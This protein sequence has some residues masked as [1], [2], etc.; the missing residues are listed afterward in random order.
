MK[1]RGSSR[2]E[3]L[4]SLLVLYPAVRTA[5]PAGRA[6]EPGLAGYWPL[7]ADTRDYSV[8]KNHG[9]ANSVTLPGASFDGTTSHLEIPDARHLHFG[10]SD[11]S[12]SLWTRVKDG[13][14]GLAGDLIAKYDPATR[15]GFSVAIKGSSGGYNSQGTDQHLHFGTDDGRLSEWEDCGRPNPTSNYISNS[16]TVFDGNLYAATTDGQSEADWAHVYRYAGGKSWVDCGRVGRQRNKGVGPMIVHGSSLYAATWSYDWERVDK[17]VLDSCNVYR[18]AGEQNWEDCGQPGQ[19]RRLFGIAA[20]KGTL[21]TVGDDKRCYVYQGGKKWTACR[22][23]INFVHPMAVYNGKLYLG[24]FGGTFDGRFHQA[25]VQSYDGTEWSSEGCPM[26]PT[27]HEDQIHALNVYRGRLYATT[28]PN[29][30]VGVLKENGEWGDCGRLG[31]STESN[32]LVVYNGK[33]YAGTIPS[34]EIYRY[35]TG[36]DWTRLKRFCP[37]DTAPTKRRRWG[38]VTSLTAYSGKLFAGL[39]SY[40]SAVEDGPADLRGRVYAV[41][42]GQCVSHDRNLGPGWHHLAVVRRKNELG[43]YVD[44]KPTANSKLNTAPCDVSN[45]VPLTIGFGPNAYF[46]GRIREVRLY[47]RAIDQQEVNRL[48]SGVPSLPTRPIPA[49]RRARGTP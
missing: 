28:W 32:A 20:F 46:S 44:G 43:V 12:I 1:N 3:L 5:P 29:G 19:C 22:S 39:G 38:R 9:T 11:F 17:E 26:G 40:S 2:R 13:I 7:D 27:N 25:E 10:T 21:Y 34:A 49:Q 42:A 47:Q 35:E 36:T 37:D 4:S 24:A 16:L 33:L 41:E 6:E 15:K 14:D 18:Y 30:W 48:R 45:S 31:E 23:F 8:F